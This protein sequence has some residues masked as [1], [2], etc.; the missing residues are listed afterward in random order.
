MAVLTDLI[1]LT[2][3]L[4]NT[5][6]AGEH[7]IMA[8]PKHHDTQKVADVHVAMVLL[9]LRSQMFRSKLADISHF[10]ITQ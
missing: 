7:E 1:K 2:L 10:P 3:V 6:C 9:F 4:I 5:A 8:S